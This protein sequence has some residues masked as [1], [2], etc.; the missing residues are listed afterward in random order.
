MFWVGSNF[1]LFD[2]W[3]FLVSD[4]Y[5]IGL[6]VRGGLNGVGFFFCGIGNG[7]VVVVRGKIWNVIFE[8]WLMVLWLKML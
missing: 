8:V 1:L 5:C 7:V 3:G 2:V 6:L 4:V